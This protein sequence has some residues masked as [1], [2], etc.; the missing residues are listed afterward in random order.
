VDVYFDLIADHDVVWLTWLAQFV[1]GGELD[2]VVGIKFCGEDVGRFAC[3][4]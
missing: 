4:V 3:Y 2:D 1:G